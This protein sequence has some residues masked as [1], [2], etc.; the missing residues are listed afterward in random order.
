MTGRR[1]R[2]MW[3][4]VF[5][6]GLLPLAFSS[7]KAIDQCGPNHPTGPCTTPCQPQACEARSY[8]CAEDGRCCPTGWTCEKDETGLWC[9]GGTVV[10]P[11]STGTARQRMARK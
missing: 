4:A 9:D 8:C 2:R 1:K 11:G 3:R 6:L 10:L 7:C 5:A